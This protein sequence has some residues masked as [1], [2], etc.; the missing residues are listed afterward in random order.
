MWMGMVGWTDEWGKGVRLGG[1]IGP[2]EQIVPG[3]G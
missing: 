3:R 2:M 1:Q